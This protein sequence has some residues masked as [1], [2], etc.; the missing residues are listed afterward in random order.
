MFS[1]FL[2]Y[3]L[4]FFYTT[5]TFWKYHVCSCINVSNGSTE[6]RL[7]AFHSSCISPC[8]NY[9]ISNIYIG[10]ISIT[11]LSAHPLLEHRFSVSSPCHLME[12]R[13]SHPN[14]R[15]SLE[16]T[17]LLCGV[18]LLLPYYKSTQSLHTSLLDLQ[19]LII[20]Y[21]T[22]SCITISYDWKST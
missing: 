19:M 16:I 22:K 2:P 8:T 3:V 5:E 9:E 7:N 21:S 15:I 17:S 11:H 20:L 4:K 18:L 10:L 13:F 12:S 1:Q 14:D 6:N